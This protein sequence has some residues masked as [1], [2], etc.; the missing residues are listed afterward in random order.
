MKEK[1]SSVLP[2]NQIN[3]HKIVEKSDLINVSEKINHKKVNLNK[4]VWENEN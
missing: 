4:V 3:K 1:S 2:I